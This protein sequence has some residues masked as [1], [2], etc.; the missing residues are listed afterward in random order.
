[1]RTLPCTITTDIRYPR[2]AQQFEF[3]AEYRPVPLEVTVKPVSGWT[4]NPWMFFKACNK[5]LWQT[6]ID[7]NPFLKPTLIFCSSRP[8]TEAA[9]KAV[10]ADM[11]MS[12]V[13]ALIS[14][15]SL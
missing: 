4:D 2:P 11:P 6:I 9:A 12:C 7:T 1:M 14:P 8:G 15:I 5:Q 3:G 10:H 13:L